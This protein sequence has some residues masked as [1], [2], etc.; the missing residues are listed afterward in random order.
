[1]HSGENRDALG[2]FFVG[3]GGGLRTVI[4]CSS[5]ISAIVKTVDWCSGRSKYVM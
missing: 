1:M 5:R 3:G 4:N 2:W